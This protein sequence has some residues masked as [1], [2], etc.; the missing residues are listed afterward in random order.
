MSKPKIFEIF[1]Y[2]IEDKSEGAESSRKAAQCP[3]M[4][5][6]CDGG[7][8]RHLSKIDLTGSGKK[9]LKEYFTG[10][11]S[12]H[13]GI[14]SIQL[15]REKAP[16]IVCPRRL[17]VLGKSD[18]GQRQHQSSVE[19]FLLKNSGLPKGTTLGVW[20]E[21]KIKY[22]EKTR[23]SKKSFNYAFDYIL[24][25][26]GRASNKEIEEATGKSWGKTRRVLESAGFSLARR[27]E[28]DYVE[29]F[30]IG[31]PIV[32]EI[33]TSST[34]GSNKKKRTTI[35][36][37]FEDAILGEP[38]NAPGINYRQIWA[39]MVSQLIVKSE[40]GIAWS[41]KTFWIL[42]DALVD[43]IS[44]ST[45]LDVHQFLAEEPSEVN[46]ISLSYGD[47]HKA[48]DGVLELKNSQL[49]SGPIRPT[50]GSVEQPS[51]QDMIRAP[52]CPSRSRLVNLLIKRKPAN[53][54]VVP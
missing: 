25:P 28:E 9:E 41:G 4:G 22:V 40:V 7:G 54:I 21:L 6:D 34:S 49:F 13:S 5:C 32:V 14:C 35:P 39:R 29:D 33:M 2:P 46:I 16:W 24:M 45:A 20:P 27:N 15:D 43:Y 50:G 51:F 8:N 23:H 44:T 42:Q 19:S 3:F 31:S 38:H 48:P 52:I 17:L 37:A 12:I 47:S 53:R 11:S 10:R 36:M 26:I 1:G 30:P 18:I